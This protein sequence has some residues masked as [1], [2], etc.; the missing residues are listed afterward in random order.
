MTHKDT[1]HRVGEIKQSPAYDHVIIIG[2]KHRQ[3]N[4]RYSDSRKTLKKSNK[5]LQ[6]KIF[7]EKFSKQNV[8]K[9]QI[10]LEPR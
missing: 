5:Y 10:F 7:C 2:H 8:K 4:H 9:I 1:L 6:N 3:N